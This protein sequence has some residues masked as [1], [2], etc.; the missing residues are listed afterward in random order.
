MLGEQNLVGTLMTTWMR[1][2]RSTPDAIAVMA[3]V[4]KCLHAADR[5]RSALVLT[6][7]AMSAIDADSG[8]P[9]V[10]RRLRS[11]I[12]ELEALENFLGSIARVS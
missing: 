9:Q 5:L 12:D 6:R 1:P 11:V 7:S 10:R 2:P 8:M 4:A 3:P